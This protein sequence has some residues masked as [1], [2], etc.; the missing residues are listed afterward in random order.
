MSYDRR[1][2]INGVASG[3]LSYNLLKARALASVSDANPM[4]G[5][6]LETSNLQIDISFDPRIWRQLGDPVLL[7][8]LN[9]SAHPDGT[10]KPGQPISLTW[11]VFDL[12]T[13]FPPRPNER[14]ASSQI[15]LFSRGNLMFGPSRQRSLEILVPNTLNRFFLFGATNHVTA[16]LSDTPGG[17]EITGSFDLFV[18]PDNSPS[19]EWGDVS[20]HY[21]WNRD[22]YTLTGILHNNAEY[23]DLTFHPLLA[24]NEQM[25]RGSV[26]PMAMPTSP[27]TGEAIVPLGHNQSRTL[28]FPA[29]QQTWPWFD[30]LTLIQYEPFSRVFNYSVDITARD[31]YGNTYAGT[32]VP[33]QVTVDIE[34]SK[35]NEQAFALAAEICGAISAVI[36]FFYPWAATVATAW[37]ATEQAAIIAALDP[38]EPDFDCFTLVAQEVA[39]EDSSKVVRLVSLILQIAKTP[40][41]LSAIES[42][43]MGAS[44]KN[45]AQGLVLQQRSYVDTIRAMNNAAQQLEKL[46]P[47]AIG[48]FHSRIK[49]NNADFQKAH[50][51]FAKGVPDDVLTNMRAAGLSKEAEILL[52]NAVRNRDLMNQLPNLD[53][54][55]INVAMQAVLLT[56]TLQKEMPKALIRKANRF[57]KNAKEN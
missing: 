50:L 15:S 54:A 53:K 52:D 11:G 17:V 39:K 22:H 31:Q 57:L 33:R 29:I 30:R 23:G 34:Q 3:F 38:P 41:T 6:M 51:A 20:A 10:I 5:A 19:W 47:E 21:H 16:E 37:F 2:F 18:I 26:L 46:L 7:I 8:Q 28:A 24:Q 36:G 44:E 43:M 13:S 42:K 49:I 9:P 14:Y 56:L 25:T 45:S 48:E 27:S 35:L 55:I 40:Q 4:V 32:S 1:K 12:F